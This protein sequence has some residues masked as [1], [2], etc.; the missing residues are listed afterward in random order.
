MTYH[1][2]YK[3]HGIWYTNADSNHITG[4]FW[5]HKTTLYGE[6]LAV[7]NYMCIVTGPK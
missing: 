5:P 3:Y 7:V 6:S 1:L 4:T 2:S